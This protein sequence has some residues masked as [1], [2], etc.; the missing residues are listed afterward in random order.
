MVLAIVA[1][2]EV[3][4]KSSVFHQCGDA[5]IFAEGGRRRQAKVLVNLCPEV[6]AIL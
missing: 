5:G 2:P 3:F 4:T 6:R 1:F